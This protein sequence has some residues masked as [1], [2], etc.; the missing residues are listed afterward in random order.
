[1]NNKIEKAVENV[2]NNKPT[3][4]EVKSYRLKSHSK[5]DDNRKD[6]LIAEIH[7]DDLLSN[8]L[9][10]QKINVDNKFE[11]YLNDLLDVAIK[12][13]DLEDIEN[14][15]QNFAM[16]Y[17]SIKISEFSNKRVNEQIYLALKDILKNNDSII[18]G[19]DIRNKYSSDNKNYG[20]AF[21][22][23]KDLSD[24]YPDRV[25]NMPISE[26]AII[27][28]STG[29]A[30]SGKSSISEIMFGDFMTLTF[31]QIYQHASKFQ[32]MYND[33]DLDICLAIRTPMGGKRGYGP[34]HSQ[35]IEKF[36]LGI[37]NFNI[38][39]IN[40]RLK[41]E[42]FYKKLISIKS[43]KLIIENKILY[44]LIPQKQKIP[45]FYEIFETD[46]DFPVIIIKPKNKY[47]AKLTILCYGGTLIELENSLTKIFQ[48]LEILVEIICFS[49]ISPIHNINPLFDSIRDTSNL[50]IVE[51]GPNYASF[52]SEIAAQILH[53][54]IILNNFERISNNSIIPSSFKA[55]SK[56]LVNNNIILE[57]IKK[58]KL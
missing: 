27:G 23:T 32:V 29:Y 37:N 25:L 7:K 52:S 34:T 36:F 42:N 45:I 3:F 6:S 35:S 12:S 14:E 4:L 19:E 30:M 56:L 39:V 40:H 24:S 18:V 31:D 26:G 38:Y 21:K 22:V 9:V 15:T 20:G 54:N 41:I 55:E 44:N 16:N 2:R 51:E 17:E 5:G 33:N 10:K 58:M 28:F 43:P 46:N 48:E 50:L 53:N 57:T 13:N 1:M 8:E 47:K 11:D 49:C